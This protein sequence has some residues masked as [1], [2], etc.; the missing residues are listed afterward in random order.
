MAAH[1][2]GR[3]RGAPCGAAPDPRRRR[4]SSPARPAR[5]AAAAR[6][7]CGAPPTRARPRRAARPRRVCAGLARAT[8]PPAR[9][10]ARRRPRR[11]P[12]PLDAARGASCA[13]A[14]TTSSWPRAAAGRARQVREP[15]RAAGRARP[16][17]TTGCWS[18][19]TTSSCPR[20]FLDGFIAAAERF[21]LEL[22]QPAHRAALATPPGASPRRRAGSSRARRLRRDRP[23]HARSRAA[24][25]ATLLPFPD[26][27]DGL[28]PRRRT[29]RRWPRERGWRLGVVD[30][31]P[32]AARRRA[33]SATAYSRGDARGRGARVPRRRGRT[34]AR[35]RPHVRAPAAPLADRHARESPAR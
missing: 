29:G 9:A 4:T 5:S 16:P 22:A 24:R 7:C 28:G 3:L 32:V 20:G 19:T 34:S 13:P 6:R 27:A 10:R 33:R 15:Q 14:A 2:R 18:S 12:R 31:V 11:A 21:D 35:E 8:P 23:G 17:R 30:A 25:S 1:T 26:A